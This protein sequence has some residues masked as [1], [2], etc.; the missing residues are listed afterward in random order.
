[1]PR[2]DH[3][4]QHGH[5]RGG[6]PEAIEQAHPSDLEA[7]RA[8]D[9]LAAVL[10]AVL[11]RQGMHAVEALVLEAGNLTDRVAANGGDLVHKGG[12]M[13]DAMAV[14]ARELAAMLIRGRR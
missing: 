5:G 11:D 2:E 8:H 12:R 3:D 1:M 10:Y 6:R 9:C 4:D 14:E 13:R 7:E